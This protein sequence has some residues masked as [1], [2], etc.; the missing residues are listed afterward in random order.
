MYLTFAS[1]VRSHRYSA[2]WM[3][4]GGRHAPNP[5]GDF[6][7]VAQQPLTQRAAR[8]NTTMPRPLCCWWVKIGRL[9]LGMRYLQET[10]HRGAVS[11]RQVELL[12]PTC[13]SRLA[14]AAPAVRLSV[15]GSSD[16]EVLATVHSL[17]GASQTSLRLTASLDSNFV[18]TAYMSLYAAGSSCSSHAHRPTITSNTII[19]EQ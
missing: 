6:F 2:F 12:S 18:S 13:P 14:S 9:D 1:R 17:L 11:F 15:Q 5:K 10:I 8:Y 3:C 16:N 4:I 7:V 19:L